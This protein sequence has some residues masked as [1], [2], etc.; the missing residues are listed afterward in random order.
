[1]PIRLGL[2]TREVMPDHTDSFDRMTMF[3]KPFEATGAI[4]VQDDGESPFPGQRGLESERTRLLF[5]GRTFDIEATLADGYDRRVH[6]E[7]A[8][9]VRKGLAGVTWVDSNTYADRS[10]ACEKAR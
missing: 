2:I 9:L 7:V 3:N 8:K 4:D 6:C 1:M 5:G 10:L